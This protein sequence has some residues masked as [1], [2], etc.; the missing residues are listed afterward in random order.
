MVVSFIWPYSLAIETSTSVTAR[1]SGAEAE[2]RRERRERQDD[3]DGSV[4]D[5]PR[6]QRLPVILDRPGD[7]PDLQRS[8]RGPADESAST[9]RELRMLPTRWQPP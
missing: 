5:H 1:A 3:H 6:W 2:Q 7:R 8:V 9:R 4:H